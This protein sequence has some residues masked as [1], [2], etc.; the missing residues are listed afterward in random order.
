MLSYACIKKEVMHFLELSL[1]EVCGCVWFCVVFFFPPATHP[2][3]NFQLRAAMAVSE[4]TVQVTAKL[5]KKKVSTALA[6]CGCKHFHLTLKWKA[7]NA[8]KK[9]AVITTYN[10]YLPSFLSHAASWHSENT[11]N[12][13]IS[14]SDPELPL[15]TPA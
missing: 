3:I 9:Q 2:S 6:S 10:T 1:S 8:S 14:V 7:I 13:V 4:L 11:F 15:C 5:G 12:K